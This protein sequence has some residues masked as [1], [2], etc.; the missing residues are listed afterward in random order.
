MKI[1]EFTQLLKEEVKKYIEK[2][3]HVEL[4][5]I[6]KNNDVQEEA[7]SIL[8]AGTNIAPTIYLKQFYDRFLDGEELAELAREIVA[9]HARC[10]ME[11]PV[12]MSI[13]LDFQKAKHRIVFKLVNFE[14]NKKL[15]TRIPH[16]IYMDLA[17][18]F[19]YLFEEEVFQNATILITQEHIK[20]WGVET[21]ALYEIAKVNTPS[22][23]PA[24]ITGMCELLEQMIGK[25]PMEGLEEENLIP[26]YVLTNREKMNGA[27]VMMYPEVIKQFA[28]KMEKNM[29]II[30][31]SIHEVILVPE[32]GM[33][34]AFLNAMV[35]EVNE[36]Q[37][38]PKEVLADHAYF[39]DRARD[40]ISCC[41]REH[42][43]YC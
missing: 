9:I 42:V 22:L 19:Y 38:D 36:T 10:Q 21:K 6:C 18:V 31:S 11:Q 35:Q 41:V 39:Y 20:M 34:G 37:V 25:K 7:L 16:I 30:P 29:Y 12:D 33:E 23:L 14:R 1:N 5:L 17:I 26:M 13:F 8:K 2:D 3:E 43:S 32:H 40:R 4:S 15:L 27:A 28:D 24:S